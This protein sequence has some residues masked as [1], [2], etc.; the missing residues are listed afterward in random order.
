[1]HWLSHPRIANLLLL[2]RTTKI[3]TKMHS[4]IM[5]VSQHALGRG[6]CIPACTGQWGV[7]QHALDRG[8]LPRGSVCPGGVSAQRGVCLE[9]WG[10]C[11]GVSVQGEGGWGCLLRGC[12]PRG[13]SAW[14]EGMGVFAQGVS[15]THP[16]PPWTEWQ[17]PVKTLPCRN[18]IV[19][20]KNCFWNHKG[21]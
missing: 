19:D 13:V 11:L 6:V 8:C 2:F 21:R 12:L 20:G 1:M 16:L 7:S 5:R 9:G 18:Y 10:V 17:T 14:G 3:L 4:S 15:A